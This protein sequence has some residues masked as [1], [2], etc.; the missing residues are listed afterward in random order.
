MSERR[1][2]SAKKVE[3]LTKDEELLFE[4]VQMAIEEGELSQDYK[5]LCKDDNFTKKFATYYEILKHTLLNSLDESS[6]IQVVQQLY[7]LSDSL[8][9]YVSYRTYDKLDIRE[10]KLM[11][12]FDQ[13]CALEIVVNMCIEFIDDYDIYDIINNT[14]IKIRENELD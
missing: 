9:N 11:F 10:S 13:L 5:Y 12:Y 3:C 6:Q 7:S 2:A 14:F 4:L 1:N 8:E